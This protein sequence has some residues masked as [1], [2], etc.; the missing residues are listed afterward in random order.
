MMTC[1]QNESDHVRI[2]C[3]W[4]DF[5]P[6]FQEVKVE[7]MVMYLGPAHAKDVE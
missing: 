5:P 3:L 6:N 1:L 4:S 2:T 7:V